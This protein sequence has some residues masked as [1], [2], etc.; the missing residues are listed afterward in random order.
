[1]TASDQSGVSLLGELCC[2][3]GESNWGGLRCGGVDFMDFKKFVFRE[4]CSL[5]STIEVASPGRW[6]RGVGF[7]SAHTHARILR[8]R[9]RAR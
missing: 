6:L 3:R 5:L 4:K 1:M 9:A 7:G 8:E 2:A